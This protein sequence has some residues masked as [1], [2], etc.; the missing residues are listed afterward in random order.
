MEA[1]SSLRQVNLGDSASPSERLMSAFESTDWRKRTRITRRIIKPSAGRS[2]LVMV[3]PTT[4]LFPRLRT[5]LPFSPPLLP[6]PLSSHWYCHS[7][8]VLKRRTS[9]KQ[10]LQRNPAKVFLAFILRAWT[11][12]TTMPC[13]FSVYTSILCSNWE[14]F[15]L[16]SSQFRIFW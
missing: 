15:Y 11:Q 7:G 14:L 1:R 6:P 4:S 9:M 2:H 12:H 10:F 16:N 3:T 13:G 8:G 5:P